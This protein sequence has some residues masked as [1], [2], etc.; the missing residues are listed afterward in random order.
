MTSCDA[1]DGLTSDGAALDDPQAQTSSASS[2]AKLYT[3]AA[4]PPL[5]MITRLLLIRGLPSDYYTQANRNVGIG[6]MPG[7]E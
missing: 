7:Q 1:R 4:F 3:T 2:P 5:A 6:Y